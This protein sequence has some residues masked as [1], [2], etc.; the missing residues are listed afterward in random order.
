[1]NQNPAREA[2]FFLPGKRLKV[3]ITDE[4]TWIKWKGG[5]MEHIPGCVLKYL[6][7][8]EAIALHRLAAELSPPGVAPR[9][10]MMRGGARSAIMV[11]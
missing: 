5:G 1:M 2:Y 10:S 8:D 7:N 3:R 6:I 4:A 9:L 11:E